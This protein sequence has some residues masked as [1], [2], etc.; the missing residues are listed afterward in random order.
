MFKLEHWNHYNAVMSDS[1][2]LTNNKS[3]SYNLQMKIT[4]PMKPN[5]YPILK[6]I[7]DEDSV[8]SAKFAACLAGNGAEDHNCGRT[9]KYCERKD[10][11]KRLLSYYKSL[12]WKDYMDALMAFIND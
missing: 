11:L 6:G 4:I 2:E 1:V 9:K 10:K 5:I 3:E 7:Q 12:P 8:S